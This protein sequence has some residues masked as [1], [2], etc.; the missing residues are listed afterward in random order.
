VLAK[1]TAELKA[2][3]AKEAKRQRNKHIGTV[4][5][6]S[7]EAS[8]ALHAMTDDCLICRN[9]LYMPENEQWGAVQLQ[10]S[11]C[12]KGPILHVSCM[13]NLQ[14]RGLKCPQCSKPFTNERAS[15]RVL[16]LP[17]SSSDSSGSSDE[18]DSDS[19]DELPLP[20]LPAPVP[21]QVQ[22]VRTSRRR[23]AGAS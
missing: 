21:V 4:C 6:S 13:I 2:K 15:S 20:A 9:K 14:N 17:A 3:E 19:E 10:C 22:S 7:N 12:T 18:S 5:D 8:L 11:G 23:T 1:R 16:R